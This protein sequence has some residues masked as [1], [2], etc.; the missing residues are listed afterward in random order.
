MRN[1][2]AEPTQHDQGNNQGNHQGNPRVQFILRIA[3]AAALG[4]F[5]FGCETVV[6]GFSH[7]R[8]AAH[9]YR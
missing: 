4:G 9:R 6:L 7:A 1:S 3:I 8:C 2:S 5:L